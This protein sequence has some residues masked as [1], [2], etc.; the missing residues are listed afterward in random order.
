MQAIKA[1]DTR[2]ELAVRRYLHARGY[3]FRLH[4]RDLPGNPD[5]VLPRYRTVIFVHGCFW[6]QHPSLTCRNAQV[7][8]SNIGYWQPKLARTVA[9]DRAAFEALEAAGWRVLTIWECETKQEEDLKS[10]LMPLLSDG[11]R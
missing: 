7:P 4:R 6:H 1:K 2:P 8:R 11:Y 9:R 5:I 3:R 10:A